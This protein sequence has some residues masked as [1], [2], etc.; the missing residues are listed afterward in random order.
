M[1]LVRD[2]IEGLDPAAAEHEVQRMALVRIV[3]GKSETIA[4]ASGLLSLIL[5][6]AVAS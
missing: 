2:Q 5:A 1:D 3:D 6:P 4:D